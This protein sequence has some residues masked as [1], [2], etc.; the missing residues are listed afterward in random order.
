MIKF[1]VAATIIGS[2]II[3]AA[4]LSTYFSP[5]QTCVRVLTNGQTTRQQASIG[6]LVMRRQSSD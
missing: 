5:F 1:I 2:A 6:C 4:G 3:G